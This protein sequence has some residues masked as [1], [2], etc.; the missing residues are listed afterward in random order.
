MCL[1]LFFSGRPNAVRNGELEYARSLNSV[2]D[3]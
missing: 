3:G 1:Y 2:F